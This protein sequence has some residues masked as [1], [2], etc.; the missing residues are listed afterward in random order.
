MLYT[1]PFIEKRYYIICCPE[2]I[3]HLH[4]KQEKNKDYICYINVQETQK[5]TVNM[6]GL[7]KINTSGRYK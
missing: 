7:T 1:S 3:L 2:N 4:R 6:A 5:P